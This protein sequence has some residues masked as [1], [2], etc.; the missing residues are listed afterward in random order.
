MKILIVGADLNS[1]LLAKFIKT[2]NKLHDIYVTTSDNSA[3]EIYTALKIRENDIKSIVEFVK[4]N[5]IEFTIALSPVAIINGIADEFKKEEF[6]IFAPYSEAARVTYFNS[7]AKKI[8]YKLKINTPRFGIFDRENLALDYIRRLNFPIVVENDFTL[9]E[10]E[11]NVYPSFSKAKLGIQKTFENGN[12]KIVIENYIDETPVY[13]Y[14]VTDGYSALPLISLERT[15]G[16]G[17][18]TIN[19]PSQKVSDEV[20][21]NLLRKVIYPILDDITKYTDNYVGILGLKIK[22]S[23]NN[24]YVHEIY[25]S[26]QYYD[27]QAFLSLLD[28]DIL[29]VLYDSANGSLGDNYGA[30]RLKEEFSYTVAVDKTHFINHEDSEEEYFESEDETKKI[31]TANAATMNK[32]QRDLSEYLQIVLKTQVCEKITCQYLERELA[33]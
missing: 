24:F 3:P 17:Y 33:L 7:I 9:V 10:R 23:N 28:E 26:F 13:V 20:Y 1:L 15:S 27:F 14:F 32:A 22:F 6:M 18:T 31:I 4:Y 16:D 21:I 19:A 2:Q 25:N 30:V 5:G 8:M 29:N 11:N 12:A